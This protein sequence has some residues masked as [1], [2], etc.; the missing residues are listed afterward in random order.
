MKLKYCL[1][2]LLMVYGSMALAQTTTTTKPK[3]A[4]TAQQPAATLPVV[5]ADGSTNATDANRILAV[6]NGLKITEA[7][8]R[9]LVR[10]YPGQIPPDA[11][12][13]EVQGRFMDILLQRKILYTKAKA[14]GFDK[15]P[16]LQQQI[17][18]A[19]ESIVADEY[20]TQKVNKLITADVLNSAYQE[21]LKQNPPQDEVKA[22]HILVK[23]EKEA[24]DIIAKISKG[25]KF[26]DLAKKYTTDPSGTQTG[27][28]L[29]YFPRGQMVLEFENAAF[30]LKPG[31][32]T[33]D[34][35]KTQFGF[36]IILV[37]D[38]RKTSSPTLEQVRPNLEQA[39][40]ARMVKQVLLD[41]AK[42]A[43]I[44]IIDETGKL[45]PWD[46]AKAK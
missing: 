3:T 15:K 43:K 41:E 25:E 24:K 2:A 29:G 39:V 8:L 32:Y 4:T 6:V 42:S 1:G 13:Q 21:F 7:D 36:H 20:L 10:N 23:T 37:E 18:Q 19:T 11:N 40:G 44:E 14:D 35:V 45:K 30:K 31:E 34:P 5:N 26:Q 22:R 17:Q 46:P 16:E 38:I 27:G 33:L 9:L 12:P 28:D